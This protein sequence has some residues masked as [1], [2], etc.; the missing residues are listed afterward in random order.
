MAPELLLLSVAGY[1]AGA[2]AALAFRGMMGRALVAAGALGGSLATLALGAWCL[3][4]GATL[5]FAAPWLPLT[6]FALR[7]DSL[8]AFFLIVV[9]LA[10]AAASI[11]GFDYSAHHDGRYSLRLLGAMFNVLLLSLTVQVLADNTLTFLVTWEVMSLSAY[12]LVLVEHDQPGTVRAANWYLAVSHAGFAALIAAF[13]VL[14]AGDMTGSFAAMRSATL[15]PATRN[16]VFLLALVGFGTKAG[17][18]PLHVWLPMAHPV[19]PSHVSAL[20]SG[21]VIKMGV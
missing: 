9:G 19:A 11:Y 13:L 7:A 14:A 3:A 17:V 20:L 18:I 8:S 12:F 6:G 1:T 2:L 5:V 4:T 16:V 10:A 21:V 15:P